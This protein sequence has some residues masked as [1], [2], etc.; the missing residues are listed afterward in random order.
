MNQQRLFDFV[1]QCSFYRTTTQ[2]DNDTYSLKDQ[3]I[4]ICPE[5][6]A[7]TKILYSRSESR[8]GGGYSMWETCTACRYS[9]GDGDGWSRAE[10][11]MDYQ[12]SEYLMT[13]DPRQEYYDS[14]CHRC[15]ETPAEPGSITCWAC[16]V[17]L[18]GEEKALEMR[19]QRELRLNPPLYVPV[20]A[21]L[22]ESS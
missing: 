15:E 6:G 5:C 8:S 22:G 1:G 4:G 13:A 10:D 17:E 19:K 18:Y 12:E 14:L 3:R 9:D 16:D 2:I 7:Q 20:V 11:G 21:A